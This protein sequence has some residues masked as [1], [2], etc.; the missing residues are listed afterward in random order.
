MRHIFHGPIGHPLSWILNGARTI[1]KRWTQRRDGSVSV[2]IGDRLVEY[3]A[4]V[5]AWVGDFIL[6]EPSYTNKVL[7]DGIP[8]GSVD[9]I[10]TLNSISSEP[11]IVEKYGAEWYLVEITSF[12][13]GSAVFQ[14]NGLVG[15]TNAHSWAIE[16]FTEDLITGEIQ[17]YLNFIPTDF[18]KFGSTI[19]AI[20]NSSVTPSDN[21]RLLRVRTESANVGAK[22]YFRLPR[23]IESKTL[24][25]S[26]IPSSRL[27][28]TTLA[29]TTQTRK[30]MTPVELDLTRGK[31][32]GAILETGTLSIDDHYEIIATTADYFG[33]GLVAGDRFTAS[34]TLAL[35]VAN[36]VQLVDPIRTQI[37]SGMINAA[38]W[39]TILASNET[40]NVL[41]TIAGIDSVLLL[42]NDGG[43]GGKLLSDDGTNV[44]EYDLDWAANTEYSFKIRYGDENDMIDA[45]VL[46]GGRYFQIGVDD[47]GGIVWGAAQDSTGHIIVDVDGEG[48]A[49]VYLS[50]DVSPFSKQIKPLLI[51]AL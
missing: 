34:S 44:A 2:K 16:G 32:S 4:D 5:V 6:T 23:L 46:P 42:K 36:S 29:A 41:S 48:K 39:N 18:V 26:V 12:N 3:A 14:I 50:W 51:E 38:A 19:S 47:G 1:G 33:V 35:S 13:S 24:P 11:V 8:Q 27:G 22:L 21:T 15:N 20:G 45:G 9:G 30:E 10:V 43:T 40:T 37:S 7:C 28:A 25:I 49:W 17:A 31:S